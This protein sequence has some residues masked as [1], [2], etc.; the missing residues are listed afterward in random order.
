L[1]T[2]AKRSTKKKSARKA[3]PKRRSAPKTAAPSMPAA[4]PGPM[5]SWSPPS[6]FGGGGDT[7][8]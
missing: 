6:D 1:K 5:P 7:D 2:A 8:T 4:E 3:A